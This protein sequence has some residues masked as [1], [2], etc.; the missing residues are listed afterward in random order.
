MFKINQTIEPPS[1]SFYA[2]YR[3]KKPFTSI[4]AKN[5]KMQHLFRTAH[6]IF[7]T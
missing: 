6:R 3:S 7:T 4:D 5:E 1:I 2:V